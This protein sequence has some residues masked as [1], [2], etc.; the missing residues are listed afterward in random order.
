MLPLAAP[1]QLCWWMQAIDIE[2]A[3]AAPCYIANP[4][5]VTTTCQLKTKK[6]ETESNGEETESCREETEPY[7]TKMESDIARQSQT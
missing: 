2:S 3:T 4:S 1:L 6:T 7:W 5:Q